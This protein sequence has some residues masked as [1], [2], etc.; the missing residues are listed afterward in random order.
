MKRLETLLRLEPAALFICCFVSSYLTPIHA[1]IESDTGRIMSWISIVL[2]L[3]DLCV[4]LHACYAPRSLN[5]KDRL[6]MLSSSA[7]PSLMLIICYCMDHSNGTVRMAVLLLRLLKLVSLKAQYKTGIQSLEGQ[8]L[9]ISETSSRILFVA[10]LSTLY[11]ST[12]AC[13]WFAISC[14]SWGTANCRRGNNWVA[15]DIDSGLMEYPDSISQYFRSLHFVMQTLLTI[16]YGDIHP[17]NLCEVTFSLVLIMSGALFY[18]YVIACITSL[19]SS[20]D[21]TTK[22]FRHDLNSLRNYL[23][24]RKAEDRI[25]DA[26]SAYLEFLYSRQLGLSEETVLAALPEHVSREIKLA[27]CLAC[28]K[29]VPFFK[30]QA[31]PDEFAE[32][33]AQKLRFVSYG[34]D[35]VV[36]A[37]GSADRIMYLIRSGKIDL[38][39]EQSRKPILSLIAGDYVGDYHMVFGFPVEVE[40]VSAGFTEV[41]TLRYDSATTCIAPPQL[42]ENM[43]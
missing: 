39:A 1:L 31:N 8:S 42:I 3:L 19:L 12:M 43:I 35:S 30:T 28:L 40:A 27:T 24:L 33:C 22:L 25:R 32:K 14:N 23:K 4:V 7:L 16:G 26:Y 37:K 38:I 15:A 18:G 34:P 11:A 29:S 13:I 2:Q 5:T 20:R 17:V 10:L 36:C 9:L 41:A 21:I 6:L